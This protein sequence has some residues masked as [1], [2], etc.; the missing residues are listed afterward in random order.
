MED[1]TSGLVPSELL[2]YFH[3]D[4]T[5]TLNC[6]AENIPDNLLVR[7]RQNNVNLRLKH[8]DL[9]VRTK[10]WRWLFIFTLNG[11]KDQLEIPMLAVQ[12]EILD[13]VIYQKS[14][15]TELWKLSKQVCIKFILFNETFSHSMWCFPSLF[16]NNF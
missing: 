6:C 7:K 10:I 3:I 13:P 9:T 2:I 11:P 16:E 8:K 15:Y 12:N 4:R 1:R 14:Y 5:A